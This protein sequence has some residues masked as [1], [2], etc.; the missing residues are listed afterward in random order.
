VADSSLLS[1]GSTIRNIIYFNRTETKFRVEFQQSDS[2]VK[3]LLN[4]GFETRRRSDF[5]LLP[6][7]KIGNN[8][9]AQLTA[10]YGF[11]DNFSQFFSDR[12]YEL[13]FWEAQPQLT[14]MRKTIF[15]T[16]LMY[17]FKDNRNRIGA[18]ENARSHDITVEAKYS[19]SG[20]SNTSIRSSFSWVNLKFVGQNNTPV[21]FAMTDGLQNGQNFLWSLSIDRSI[22][23]NIQ[24]NIGYEGRKT[25]TASVVHVGRAQIRA[26]F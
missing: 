3:T 10:I 21:Q 2:R 13:R 24:L 19:K 12:N 11:N 16:S 15:R 25:G 14:Y 9:R 18:M 20:K 22:S 6:S 17:K 26:V 1:T 4:I 5:S 7:F 23:K 8:F